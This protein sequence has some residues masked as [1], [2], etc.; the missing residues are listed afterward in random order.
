MGD[1]VG[2]ALGQCVA[3]AGAGAAAFPGHPALVGA[4]GAA[5]AEHEARR[6]HRQSKDRR[7]AVEQCLTSLLLDRDVVGDDDSE[8][9]KLPEH[10]CGRADD[11]GPYPAAAL[12]DQLCGYA[13]ALTA[14]GWGPSD[15]S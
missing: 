12:I 9:W 7:E 13:V 11:A 4:F 5:L 10:D 15:T 3:D 8:L 2:D 6:Q 14:D 1:A